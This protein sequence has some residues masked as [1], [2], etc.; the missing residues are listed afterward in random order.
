MSSCGR[1]ETST[2]STK[3]RRRHQ[4]RT[5][6]T[7]SRKRL[8]LLLRLCITHASKTRRITTATTKWNVSIRI[9]WSRVQPERRR[10]C[11]K[12]YSLLLLLL[13]LLRLR[14]RLRL[15]IETT[16]R[17]AA[18]R[19]VHV[20]TRAA[21]RGS[22]TRSKPCSSDCRRRG[23]V[24]ERRTVMLLLLL[25]IVLIESKWRGILIPLTV[26]GVVRVTRGVVRIASPH[27][28]SPLL[29]DSRRC[30]P[31]SLVGARAFVPS[32]CWWWWWRLLLLLL[33]LLKAIFSFVFEEAFYS[34]TNFKT[35]LSTTVREEPR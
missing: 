15:L 18:V 17:V 5:S 33:L 28:G 1:P 10:R 31:I 7:K 11:I 21:K 26:P 23:D 30:R 8:L 24:P 27:R 16:Q 13:L 34:K 25:M 4:S 32:R 35:P 22:T 14:L 2:T 3:R 20:T 12:S 6:I 19:G 29:F 9:R